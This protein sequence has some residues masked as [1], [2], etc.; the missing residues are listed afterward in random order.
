M[1]AM[2]R[3]SN[4]TVWHMLSIYDGIPFSPRAVALNRRLE[5]IPVP[6]FHVRPLDAKPTC[7]AV[8]CALP[9]RR[10]LMPFSSSLSLSSLTRA[11]LPRFT[12]ET[13]RMV[14]VLA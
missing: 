12:I 11:S 5:R 2:T 3:I 10:T 14:E 9:S 8:T 6:H 7:R 4:R 1:I 13:R